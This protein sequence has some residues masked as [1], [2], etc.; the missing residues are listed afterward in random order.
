M[1]IFTATPN[2]KASS[3]VKNFYGPEFVRKVAQFRQKN[4]CHDFTMTDVGN[5]IFYSIPE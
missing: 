1:K 2:K 4:I 3:T 5:F